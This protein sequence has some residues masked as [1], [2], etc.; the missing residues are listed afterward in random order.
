MEHKKY[1]RMLTEDETQAYR[2]SPCL[3]YFTDGG[4]PVEVTGTTFNYAGKLLSFGGG[5]FERGLL[6]R[7]NGVSQDR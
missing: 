2:P 1:A 7:E 4:E 3:I 5:H 6:V